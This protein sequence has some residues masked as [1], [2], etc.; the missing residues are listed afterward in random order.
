MRMRCMLCDYNLPLPT[1][2][3]E[4]KRYGAEPEDYEDPKT[5]EKRKRY[6]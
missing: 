1:D 2:E 3:E 4:R 6:R 5:K